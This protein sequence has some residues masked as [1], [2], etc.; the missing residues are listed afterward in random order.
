MSLSTP[1]TMTYPEPL[2]L[3]RLL[4]RQAAPLLAV[5]ETL[6]PECGLALFELDGALFVQAGR[7]PP[8][9][10]TRIQAEI[11][12]PDNLPAAARHC[13]LYAGPRPVGALVVY[14]QAGTTTE[15]AE[16][17]LQASLQLLLNQAL[18][19]REI[20]DDTLHRYRELTLLYRVGETIGTALNPEVIPPL[21]LQESQR[22][23][24]AD[25][26]V[27]VGVFV[28][29]RPAASGKGDWES[30]ASFGPPEEVATLLEV[31][32]PQI[33]GLLEN[34]RPVI[35][36]DLSDVTESERKPIYGS[37]LWAP[38][39]TPKRVLG[40][41]LLGRLVGQPEFTSSDEKLLTAL[42]MQ[43]ALA[44]ENAQL[45]A[46]TDEK[47]AQRVKEL[48]QE[49]T[50]RQQAEAALREHAQELEVR[51]KE[52]DA[53]SH[54]VAHD[55]QGPLANLLGYTSVLQEDWSDLSPE[56]LTDIL[57]T[58]TRAGRKMSNIIDELLLLASVRKEEAQSVPLE[59]GQIIG[60][61]QRRLD[62]MLKE[63]GAE[64]ILPDSWPVALGYAPWVEEIWANYLSNA[65]KYGG[66]PLRLEVG[67][68]PQADGMVR[69]W[70]R[71][72]GAGLTPAEQSHLFTP[73]AKFNQ[74]RA[75]GHG[76]GLSI[77]Q[78]I[79]EKLGGQVGVESQVGQ[80]SLFYF[81]LPG[82]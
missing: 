21:V 33:D 22:V 36:T 69:F 80:G 30:R 3:R 68:T 49:I 23:I 71:D 1:E 81:S 53:F 40:G 65:I 74:V 25:V 11:S 63:Y 76:L 66:Q 54:T 56:Q 6:L 39:K 61:V 9:V 45:F 77:V 2:S 70:V 15:A 19:K 13:P 26:G 37:A 29:R 44:L 72:N 82:G 35:L 8:A 60:E 14:S 12:R 75:K 42:A 64:L 62:Y 34:G 24:Q 48:T 58:I 59:M 32:Q 73:F 38:L 20:A 43:S 55:L 52:L 41:I 27:E 78:R 50:K 5:F 46:R 47:L 16:Q 67:A 79:V 10:L 18:E 28:L 51:N 4:K 31:M 57:Q 17:A 7:W